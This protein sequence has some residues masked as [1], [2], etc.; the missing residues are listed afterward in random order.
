MSRALRSIFVSTTF[1]PDDSSVAAV[2][3]LCLKHGITRLELG[4]NHR[5]EE[6]FADIVSRFPCEYL[7]HNYFPIPEEPFVVNIASLNDKIRNRSIQHILDAIDF[8]AETKAGLY[9]FHPGFLSDPEK[10]GRSGKSYDFL[11][12]NEKPTSKFYE[13]AFEKM[14]ES[15]N[16]V[17]PHAGKMGIPVA[18]ETEGSAT[19][20]DHLLMQHPDEY[21]RFF[22]H[23]SKEEI[24]INLNLGHLNL[25]SKVFGFSKHR[26]VEF[27]QDYLVAME[28]S[29]NNGEI[30]E[31]LPLLDE[32]W[33]WD[34]I[35]DTRF[36]NTKKILE[37]RNT[38]IEDVVASYR[39]VEKHLT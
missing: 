8:C 38:S 32:A 20:P 3:R 11:F 21:I 27:I 13:I 34:F 7:V 23:F 33:Y 36:E 29:H 25:A 14:I 15:I 26:F 2:I 35:S 24:G 9:T 10:A 28:L 6:N 16:T 22:N 19:K 17:I 1:M 30:D 31:H 39:K 18:I 12:N 4:S 37:F 5:Y